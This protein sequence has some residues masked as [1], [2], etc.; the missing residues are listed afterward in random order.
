M[1]RD[2]K[3]LIGLRSGGEWS[4]PGGWLEPN[5]SFG[6]CAIRELLE[7]T[8]L[9]GKEPKVIFVANNVGLKSVSIFV[10]L[11]C[12]QGEPTLCEPDKCQMWKWQDLQQPFPE[13]LFEPLKNLLLTDFSSRSLR[14]SD[15][16]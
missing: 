7:E 13:P 16:R 2:G 11:Q 15:I 12:E 10:Q 5:E 8:G 3:V 9:V 1:L 6:E 14:C 4:L